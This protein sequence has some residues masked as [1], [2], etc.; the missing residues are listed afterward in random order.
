[1]GSKKN[2]QVLKRVRNINKI[3]NPSRATIKSND[4]TIILIIINALAQI[5]I[6]KI[7]TSNYRFINARIFIIKEYEFP[8][9]HACITFHSYTPATH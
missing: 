2:N 6:A 7:Y 5:C 4:F 1:M 8:S 9:I 3:Q